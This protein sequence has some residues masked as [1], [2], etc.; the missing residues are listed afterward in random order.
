L[1]YHE[2]MK[3][4]VKHILVGVFLVLLVVS[5]FFLRAQSQPPVVTKTSPADQSKDVA[6]DSVIEIDFNKQLNNKEKSNL[7]VK[8]SPNTETDN[9][10]N[11][12]TYR[13]K[14]KA[15]LFIDTT[16]TVD[17]LYNNTLIKSFSFLTAL[18]IPGQTNQV[19]TPNDYKT[20][21]V[22]KNF[23]TDNPWYTSLPIDN[24][25]YTIVYD[26]DK[27]QFRIRIKV[28]ITSDSQKQDLINQALSD[29]KNI[30]V[31]Q[32]PIPYYV[33]IQ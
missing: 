26:F 32:T 3:I 22:I 10:W 19:I 18:T 23:V 2:V 5:V 17:V 13:L 25:S 29:L 4:K 8:I 15:N 20:G 31:T 33:L 14:P 28:P 12:K 24:S 27:S 9:S 16:Y 21:Q 1:G 30:G 11:S 7:I 6:V